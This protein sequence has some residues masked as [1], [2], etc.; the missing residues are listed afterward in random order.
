M[1]IVIVKVEVVEVVVV[2]VDV[3]EFD[4]IDKCVR[5]GTYHWLDFAHQS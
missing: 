1:M 5:L 2:M 3:V 4:L